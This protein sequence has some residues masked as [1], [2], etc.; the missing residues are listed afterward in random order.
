MA[1]ARTIPWLLWPF[2]IVWRLLELVFIVTGRILGILLALGLMVV[3]IAIAMMTAGAPLGVP[4]AV[5]GFL[6]MI[7]S[8][9]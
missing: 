5:L 2:V 3:G 6:L 8:I 9:F 7:R 4:I 1:H